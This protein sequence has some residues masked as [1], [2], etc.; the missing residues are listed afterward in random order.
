MSEVTGRLENWYY[1]SLNHVLWG[2][3]YDDIRERWWD[4]AY[5]HTSSLSLPKKVDVLRETL[6]EGN[7]V[8]T[9]NSVYLLG[10]PS[11]DNKELINV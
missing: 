5:I 4:G 10:K 1:D 3:I 6:V 11:V 9:R 8:N 7:T 2:L